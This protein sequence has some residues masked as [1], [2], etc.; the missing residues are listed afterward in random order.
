MGVITLL[1]DLG[2]SDAGV[3]NTKG[4]LLQE[5]PDAQIIDITHNIQP[6]YL[7]QAAYLLASSIYH[8]PKGSCHLVLF[9]IFYNSSPQLVLADVDGQYIL[10]P[11]NGLLPLA[12]KNKIGHAWHCYDIDKDGNLATW[13]KAAAGVIRK[14]GNNN[15]DGIG[16]PTHTF[17]QA[18][19]FSKPGI[20]GN[21]I[22]CHVMYIDRFENVVLN[23]TRDEFEAAA[24]GRAFSINFMRD[25]TITSI[26]SHYNAV[27]QGEKLCRFNSAGYL[28]IAINKGKAASLFGLRVVHDEQLLYNTIKINFE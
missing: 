28:E 11:D 23:I 16:L 2:Y 10:A 14:L 13:V 8:F 4:I 9:D 17:Q 22:E 12:F 3:A 20:F 25:D 19:H 24:Q 15:P 27:R 26:S 18:Q 5:L 21:Y 1:S 7:Q 6:F